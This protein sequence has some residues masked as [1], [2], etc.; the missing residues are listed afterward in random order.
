MQCQESNRIIEAY[1]DG[2][3]DLMRSVELEDHL[4]TCADCNLTLE[5]PSRSQEP[6]AECGPEDFR[7]GVREL[8]FST[9]CGPP[10][11]LQWKRPRRKRRRFR[12]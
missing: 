10:R 6:V 8:K 9:R 1:L 5:K 4:T 3:I 7:P 12:R 2:E 11:R